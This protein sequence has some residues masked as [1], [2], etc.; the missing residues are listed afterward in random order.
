MVIIYEKISELV[1]KHDKMNLSHISENTYFP[2]KE[3]VDFGEKPFLESFQHT[4]RTCPGVV[5]VSPVPIIQLRERYKPAQTG[6][7][8]KPV[9][10]PFGDRRTDK[11]AAGRAEAP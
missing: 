11:T 5:P 10:D 8:R 3:A 6:A 4:A 1:K 7:K 9:P 2:L